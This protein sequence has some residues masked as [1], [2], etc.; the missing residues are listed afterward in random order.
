MTDLVLTPV[1]VE[2]SGDL[3]YEEGT[4]SIKVPGSDGQSMQDVGKYVVVWK[5]GPEGTW[6]LHRDMLRIR[7]SP[8]PAIASNGLSV[9]V[10]GV[11]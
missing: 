8:R 10:S 7:T 11:A 9:Q 1:A 4:Y 2:E 5:K 3:A 6:Q